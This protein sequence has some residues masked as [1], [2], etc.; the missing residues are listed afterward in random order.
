M[1]N[2]SI[3]DAAFDELNDWSNDDAF[4]FDDAFHSASGAQMQAHHAKPAAK[5][6]ISMPY[7]F[8]VV[9]TDAGI[10]TVKLFGS[11][12]NRTAENFGNPGTIAITYD[13]SGFWGGGSNGYLALLGRTE[14]HPLTFGRLRLESAANSLNL[15]TTLNVS[16]FDPTGKSTTYPVVNFAKL[17]Q[18]QSNAIETEIDTVIFGGVELSYSQQPTSTC[19]WYFYPADVAA[20]RRGLEG[21]GVVKNLR[22]PDTYLDQTVKLVAPGR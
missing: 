5:A 6:P 14:T 19:R 2:R 4:H 16:E 20:L 13:L 18:Y 9:S 21:K 11:E 7:I 1:R 17:N 10:Q 8:T 22:R 15:S 3:L 12:V